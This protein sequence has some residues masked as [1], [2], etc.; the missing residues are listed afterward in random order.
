MKQRKGGKLFCH[1]RQIYYWLK[2]N[3]KVG[4]K[5]RGLLPKPSMSG[6]FCYLCF[7]ALESLL[8]FNLCET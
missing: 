8:G 7:F 2:T 6:E 4:S 1:V 5:N 3:Q